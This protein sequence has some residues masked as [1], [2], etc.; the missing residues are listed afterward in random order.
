VIEFAQREGDVRAL[1]RTPDE[2]EQLD[3]FQERLAKGNPYQLDAS[4]MLYL[5]GVPSMALAG[6]NVDEATV[7]VQ[8]ETELQPF[9][10]ALTFLPL[11]PVGTAALRPFGY[12][13]FERTPN[14][15]ATD[16]PV[17]VD[18]VLGPGDTVNVQLFGGSRE[19]EMPCGGLERAQRRERRQTAGHGMC[20][21]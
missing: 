10:V 17:P 11:V 9:T 5:P 19:A 21:V 6:L 18:Y 7:R 8:A 20:R 3:D 15:P 1:L 13:L 4:G 14:A 12:D 2:Q 16:I